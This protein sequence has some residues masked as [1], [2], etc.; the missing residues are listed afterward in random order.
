MILSHP[1]LQREKIDETMEALSAANEDARDVS[2]AIRVGTAA[3]HGADFV[4]EDVEEELDALVR[5]LHV[6]E[7]KQREEEENKLTERLER[8]Q[9]PPTGPVGTPLANNVVHHAPL[10]RVDL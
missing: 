4:E 7:K 9:L 8:L 1:S 10:V 3:L 2:E 5:E 6:D